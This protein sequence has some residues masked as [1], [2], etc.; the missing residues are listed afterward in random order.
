MV[1]TIHVDENEKKKKMTHSS[2]NRGDLNKLLMRMAKS[3]ERSRI[4]KNENGRFWILQLITTT[5]N[6]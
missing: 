6:R 4:Q 3:E 2:K 5:K 1:R